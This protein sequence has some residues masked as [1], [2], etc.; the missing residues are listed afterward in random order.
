MKSRKLLS[1]IQSSDAFQEQQI[2]GACLR[3]HSQAG[4]H[5]SDKTQQQ[6]EEIK[7][8]LK[9]SNKKKDTTYFTNK[10][11]DSSTSICAKQKFQTLSSFDKMK[12][13]INSSRVD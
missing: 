5:N 6:K 2:S 11:K 8:Y 3:S 13:S 9:F 10:I 12:K 4:N 1:R 7:R